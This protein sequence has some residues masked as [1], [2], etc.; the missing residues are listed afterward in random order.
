MYFYLYQNQSKNQVVID[1]HGVPLVGC[2]KIDI[3]TLKIYT[4]YVLPN[5]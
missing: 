1:F 5:F 3:L 4:A 2:P